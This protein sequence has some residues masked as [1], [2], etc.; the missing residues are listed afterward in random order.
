MERAGHHDD[1]RSFRVRLRDLYGV[2]VRF[3]AAVREHDFVVR[4]PDRNPRAE[5]LGQLNVAFVR[6]DVE[7]PV[8]VS[9]GLLLHGGDQ[10]GDARA[11]R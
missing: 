5:L 8:K 6:H 3:R 10:F 2:L 11:R 9:L 7:H 1:V 4:T